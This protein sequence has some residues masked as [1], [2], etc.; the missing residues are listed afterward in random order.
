MELAPGQIVADYEI[1]RELG[2]G[3]MGKVF[4]V[5]NTISDRMEA[6]KVLLTDLNASP[7][8][9]ERFLREI[10][11]SASLDH[12][13]IAA[14]RTA[15]RLDNQ[16]VMI[17][18]Y[19]EGTSLDARMRRGRV[20]VADGVRY[21]SQA[22]AGL[23]YAHSH[24]VIH[25][26]IKPGNIMLPVNGEA[27]VLDFGIATVAADRKLTKT[28]AVVG[29]LH[30][31]SPEQIEGKPLDSRSDLYSLGVTLYEVVTGKR[32]F[33]GPSEFSV[34]NGHLRT[35]PQPPAEIEPSIPSQL[36]EI[37]LM[38]LCK[39]PDGRFQTA[40]AFGRALASVGAPGVVQ[41]TREIPVAPPPPPPVQSIPP[42]KKDRRLLY[43]TA[44]SLATITLLALAVIEIPK[45]MK[46]SAGAPQPAPVQAPVAPPVTE[47][48]P[49]PTPVVQPSQ[50]PQTN[51]IR[52]AAAQPVQQAPAPQAL[53]PPV[54]QQQQPPP[55]VVEPPVPAPQSPPVDTAQLSEL[56]DRL[57]L[58]STR[59]GA[60]RVSI[61][62]LQREMSKSGLGLRS[63]IVTAQQRVDYQMDEAQNA[64]NRQ[65]IAGSK[66]RLDTAEQDVER[67]EKFLGR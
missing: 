55:Q 31:M 40:D 59:V 37:I 60:A 15:L 6:M 27:K 63:D 64:I 29:S 48:Q 3:G 18:E 26:D 61:Q 16:L 46:T 35:P 53:P 11:I 50:I 36:S 13:N 20:P 32:P 57:M 58:L 49:N 7:D 62:N 9:A 51:P 66:K 2:A 28:G 41:A 10:K 44:G 1:V 38:A 33:D 30:Y 47:P 12:P 34:M 23:A 17:M 65:D 24:G 43:M 4:Q 45:Y 52:Q 8:L 42:P 39:D 19:V 21:I 22:L 54:Q 67:L 14:L 25:R 56:R 5:R